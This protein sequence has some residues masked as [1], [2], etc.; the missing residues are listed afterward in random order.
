MTLREILRRKVDVAS[1][2]ESVRA[3][4]ERM[5]QR[6]VGCLVVTDLDDHPVGILTDRDL[7]LRVLSAGRDPQQTR[8]QDVMTARPTCAVEGSPLED[9]IAT[10]RRGGFR[11]LP[12]VDGEGRLSGIIALDDILRDISRRFLLIGQLLE[13]ESPEY[14]A[15]GM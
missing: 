11:R 13:R 12:I 2:S 7:T 5:R 9:V 4:A 8:V 3:V 15:G 6:S 1:P 10:L 14:Q